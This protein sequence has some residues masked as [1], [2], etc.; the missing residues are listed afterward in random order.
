[1]TDKYKIIFSNSTS[2]HGN[3]YKSN[4]EISIHT[5]QTEKMTNR[6]ITTVT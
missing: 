5:Y 4:T 6:V 2:S 1:M 3:K